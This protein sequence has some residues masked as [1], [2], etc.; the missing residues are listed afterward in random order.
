MMKLSVLWKIDATIEPD[1]NS[2]VARAL[3]APWEHAPATIQFVRSSANFLY[4]FQA[5]GQRR[6]L[7]FIED[8]ERR[9]E[10]IVAEMS[11][12]AGLSAAGIAVS[13][14][15]ASRQRRLVETADTVWGQFHAVVFPALEGDQLEVEDLDVAGMRTWGRIL[16]RLHTVMGLPPQRL[17]RPTW[18][19]RLSAIQGALP[20]GFPALQA[21]YRRLADWLDT[22]PMTPETYGMI[23]GDF[24]LDNL[25]WRNG[26]AAVLDFDDSAFMWYVA[27][28][29]FAVRDLFTSDMDLGDPRFQTFIAGYRESRPLSDESLEQTPLFLRFAQLLQYARIVRTLDFAPDPMQPEWL[30]ALHDKLARLAAA[31]HQTIETRYES[32][33]GQG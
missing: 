19:D 1:G 4:R 9:R 25:I 12:L 33:H 32:R 2:P 26:S 20:P 27:D 31:Y 6:F 28:V 21:E 17:A 24:E 22:L 29:A 16:G 3:L 11:L 23:H 7:R 8:S 14:P 18:R 13:A 10:A 5:Q 15:I 30:V